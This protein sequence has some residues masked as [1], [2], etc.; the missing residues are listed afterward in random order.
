MRQL[1]AVEACLVALRK[2]DVVDPVVVESCWNSTATTTRAE[3]GK[4]SHRLW[5]RKMA[6]PYLLNEG[7]AFAVAKIGV[8]TGR[9]E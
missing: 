7:R 3:G 4:E 5:P 9:M 6:N 8:M 1:N 2:P